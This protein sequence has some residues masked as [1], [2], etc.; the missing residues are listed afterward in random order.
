MLFRSDIMPILQALALRGHPLALP[1]SAGNALPPLFRRWK[2]GAAMTRGLQG[3][4]EPDAT[5]LLAAPDVI[6]TPI[7]G[8]D[9]RGWRLG[10]GAGYYDRAIFAARLRGPVLAIGFAYAAQE[11]E[12]I[13]AEAHDAAMDMI[14]TEDAILRMG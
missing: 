10:H 13:P 5:A 11:C 12:A 4:P 3:I 14:V 7:V 8:F 2:E 1:C 9:R 6:L